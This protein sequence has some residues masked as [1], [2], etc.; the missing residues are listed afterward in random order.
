MNKNEET[1]AEIRARREREFEAKLLQGTP[2][3]QP[4]YPA[5]VELMDLKGTVKKLLA[6]NALLISETIESEAQIKK[7][8]KEVDWWETHA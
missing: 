1:F 2:M 4:K 6:D 3:E 5:Y 7:L 8:Q